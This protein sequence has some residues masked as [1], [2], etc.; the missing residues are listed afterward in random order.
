M[1]KRRKTP[2]ERWAEKHLRT[3]SAR[4]KT[5]TQKEF[6]GVCDRSQTSMHAAVKGYILACILAGRVISTPECTHGALSTLRPHK[7]KGSWVQ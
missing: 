5:H 2:Q 6:A 7:G 3:V 1:E 4:V